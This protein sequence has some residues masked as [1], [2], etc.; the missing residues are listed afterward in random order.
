MGGQVLAIIGARLN[1]SRL[2]AKQLLALAGRPMIEHIFTRLEQVKQLDDIII[3]TTADEFN[4]PLVNWAKD[5][6]KNVFAFDADVDDLMGRIDAVIKQEN[7][8]II[9][10]ICGDCPLINPETLDGLITALKNNPTAEVAHFSPPP[11]GKS[12][13]HEG[14][15]IYRR[16]FW[17]KMIAVAHEPFEREHVGAVYHALNKVEPNAIAIYDEDNSYSQIQHR[18]SVDT[19]ADYSFMQQVYTNWYS[20]NDGTSIVSL[21]WV[22]EQ[23]LVTPNLVAINQNVHQKTINEQSAAVII[24]LQVGESIGL[25]HFSRMVNL[26]H[27]LQNH[28]SSGVHLLIRG[29]ELAHPA[30]EHLPHTFIDDQ[31]NIDAALRKKCDVFV[32]DLKNDFC[33]IQKRIDFAKEN[34]IITIAIDDGTTDGKFNLDNLDLYFVPSIF[35]P[36]S[37]RDRLGDQLMWGLNC[38]LVPQLPVR[39]PIDKIKNIIILTGGSDPTN[40]GATLPSY[41]D[42]TIKSAVEITWV[43]GPYAKATNLPQK[44]NLKWHLWQNPENLA[45]KLKDFDLAITAFGSSFFE[46]IKSGVPAIVFDEIG[47]A[48]PEEWA[49]IAEKNLGKL[50]NS[51][52][53]AV[54]TA[55]TL[56]AQP[57]YL[58]DMA[59][60]A[61]SQLQ[62]SGGITLAERIKAMLEDDE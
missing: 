16:S 9:L 13:I 28:I 50:A 53:D 59:K 39:A 60:N 11:E 48:T 12:Y 49:V 2:P 43:E 47:A 1:S 61:Q 37:L 45:Q 36:Q 31:F 41:I 54:K 32:F 35:A 52:T 4:K 62:I 44:P 27:D 33:Q 57:D 40:L 42:K 58:S 29:G 23:L 56:T 38:M 14:F 17:D 55:A 24:L 46:C 34:D 20:Q 8:D 21:H 22:I 19:P 3:A 7:P 15:D 6:K 51:A 18:I 26:A 10:Y 25:G 30:L 5:N